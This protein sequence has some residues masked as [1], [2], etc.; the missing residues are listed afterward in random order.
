[1]GG[2]HVHSDL[3]GRSGHRHPGGDQ[4]GD[5]PSP[6]VTDRRRAVRG[7]PPQAATTRGATARATPRSSRPLNI[8][9]RDGTLTLDGGAPRGFQAGV[10]ALRVNGE[11]VDVDPGQTAGLPDSVVNVACTYAALRDD[12]THGTRTTADFDDAVRLAHLVDDILA[13][14]ANGQTATTFGSR[15]S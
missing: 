15:P 5:P 10:L 11:P 6:A 13:A 7:S 4:P 2:P 3:R 8:V 14:A 9:G 1:M 12:I